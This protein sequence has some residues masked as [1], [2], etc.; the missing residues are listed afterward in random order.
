MFDQLVFDS[1]VDPRAIVPR[2]GWISIRSLCQPQIRRYR[3]KTMSKKP[4]DYSKWDKIELSDDE[5]D[6]HPNIDRESWFRMKH[7]S[8]VE[9]EDGEDKDKA[10]LRTDMEKANRRIR[11][12]EHDLKKMAIQ[13]KKPAADDAGDKDNKDDND[14]EDSDDD[15][16]EKE[17]WET[18]LRQLQ[19]DNA[20]RQRK[21]DDYEKNKKW[22][23]D[24]L[25]TLKEERTLVNKTAGEQSFS[26]SG[27]VIDKTTSTA[28]PEKKTTGAPTTTMAA[29][30]ETAAVESKLKAAPE[31]TAKKATIANAEEEEEEEEYAPPAGG[32]GPAQDHGLGVMETYHEFTERH[33]GTVELFMQCKTFDESREFLLQH[34][35]VILQE[36]ASNYLLL[37]S[38]EDEMNGYRD[39]M[40]LTARQS[41][42][43][44]NI[45]ELAK[46]V[47]TH[48]GNVIQPFFQR[49]QERVH[50][51]E[52]MKGVNAFVDKIIKRAVVKKAEIDEERRAQQATT[53]LHDIPREQ[54]LGPG[55]LD[56]LEVIETLPESIQE[57]FE[58]RDA[59]QL[60][61]ALE[62]LDPADAEYHMKRCVDSGL[63]VANA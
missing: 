34:A 61:R 4:F 52:F 10:K 11:V 32:V 36:N 45:A 48:P 59:D 39:K 1:R 29:G 49:M 22:N 30:T 6:V 18:E 47:K 63:W 21:L 40:K 26:P 56:P 14:D 24:N 31:A 55:G 17:G 13:K 38:L 41:Q 58:S 23:V 3:K 9:R 57:A 54:R 33:A 51:E 15:E 43:I 35:D 44:T 8:R 28:A 12:L 53:D 19:E 2:S 27:F 42:I 25:S 16:L 37:A 46:T 20:E 50:L 62:E 7:R 5:D 60:R